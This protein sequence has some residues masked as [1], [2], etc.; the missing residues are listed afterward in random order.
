MLVERA[1][2][3]TESVEARLDGILGR[4]PEAPNIPGK[5]PGRQ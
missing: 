2:S 4:G 1:P 5:R 3:A